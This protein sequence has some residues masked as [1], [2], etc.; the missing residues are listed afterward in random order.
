MRC[1]TRRSASL[2]GLFAVAA[3]LPAAE[4]ATVVWRLDQLATVGGQAPE[5]L[6]AP[7][8]VALD[9]VRAT[10][11]DGV[12]D[13]LFLP[14]NPLAG[15][16]AFTIEVLFRPEAGGLA[17]QRFLHIQDEPDSR[18]LLEIR[19]TPDGRWALDTFLYSTVTKGSLTLLD[20]TKLHS[21]GRW[22]WVALRY[23]GK[24]MTSFVDGAKELAGAV[25]F[26]PTA[27]NGRVSLGV[28]QN[29]VYWFKGAIAEVRITRSALPK[30][31]LQR[32]NLPPPTGTSP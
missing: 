20:R 21:A 8:V 16:R 30:E 17:E 12:A 14:I 18:A 15:A 1:L 28:R 26:P 4:P 25:D 32:T 3:N 10:R 6:G 19:L 2:L 13:G 11:F 22:H 31:K 27:A 5:A 7:K 24:T 23:D 29:K 9:G